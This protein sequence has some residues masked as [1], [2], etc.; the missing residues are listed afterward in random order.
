MASTTSSRIPPY[1]WLPT[2]HEKVHFFHSRFRMCLLIS[3]PVAFTRARAGQKQQRFFVSKYPIAHEKNTVIFL[4]IDPCD[5]TDK[6]LRSWLADHRPALRRPS[7]RRQTNSRRRRCLRPQDPYTGR[8]HLA[9]LVQSTTSASHE[10]SPRTDE[11][12]R[13]TQAYRKGD[14]NALQQWGGA[15]RRF[16]ANE[17]TQK[18]ITCVPGG[19]G[20]IPDRQLLHLAF[21]TPHRHRFQ[22][23]DVA[24]K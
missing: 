24:S 11:L 8:T 21:H 16:R 23:P 9:A 1:H 2:E 6:P 3:C 7:T 12:H 15:R 19:W 22:R 20:Y 13:L 4:Y 18:A 5:L 14:L 10:P 17:R